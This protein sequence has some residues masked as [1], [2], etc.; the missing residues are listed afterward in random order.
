MKINLF[1]NFVI[2]I[3]ILKKNW[4]V[5]WRGDGKTWL[6][7]LK[8]RK[9]RQG[10]RNCKGDWKW[11]LGRRGKSASKCALYL[12][13]PH[14]SELFDKDWIYFFK[15]DDLSEPCLDTLN[16]SE[17]EIARILGPQTFTGIT[18]GHDS[19]GTF[20]EDYICVLI[21]SNKHLWLY[22]GNI[23]ILCERSL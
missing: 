9:E 12:N 17:K 4:N 15:D 7:L 20:G 6:G 21:Y 16:P 5:R 22:Q 11:S 2:N 13:Y 8:K 14:V 1:Q 10:T 19:M 18:G 23:H 3:E